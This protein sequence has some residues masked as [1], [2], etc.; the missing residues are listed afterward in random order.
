[1]LG[2]DEAS[3]NVD[4]NTMLDSL[5][6]AP[7]SMSVITAVCAQDVYWMEMPITCWMRCITL[8]VLCNKSSV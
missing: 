8:L 2:L 1:M 3:E 5:G 6:G 7:R 4:Y